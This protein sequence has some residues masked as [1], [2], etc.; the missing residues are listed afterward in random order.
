MSNVAIFCAYIIRVI[1]WLNKWIN[2]TNYWLEDVSIDI[3]ALTDGYKPYRWQ[4]QKSNRLDENIRK[5]NV[6]SMKEEVEKN[7]M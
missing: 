5:F 6:S 7:M 2:I 1:H 4:Y 3:R